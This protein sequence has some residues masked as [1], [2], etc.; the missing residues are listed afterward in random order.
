MISTLLQAGGPL[1]LPE[2][3]DGSGLGDE[4]VRPALAELTQEKLVVEGNL[5]SDKPAPHYVWAARW[6]AEAKRRAAGSRQTLE[7]MVTPEDGMTVRRLDIE[8]EAVVT[9]CNYVISQY[10][11]P[12]DKRFLVFLQCSVRRPFSTSPSHASMRRAIEVATGFDPRKDFEK[13][14]VHVVVLAS[15]I[16]PVPYELEDVYPANVKGGGVKHFSRDLYKR[17]RP[18]LADRMAQ[19][20]IAHRD[21]YDRIATFTDGQYADVM[22]ET[23]RIAVEHCGKEV[24]FP[25]LPGKDGCRITQMGDSMPRVYWE[26]YWIQLYLEILSWL[27]PAQRKQAEKRLRDLRVSYH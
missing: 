19:Y 8:D 7:A 18:I 27:E 26:K 1:T 11:P 17:L 25:I 23:R 10:M 9:F 24:D 13:C 5:F 12:R 4:L 3:V 20:I 6:Q 14:P 21:S 16:G 2:I 22:Q 15:K